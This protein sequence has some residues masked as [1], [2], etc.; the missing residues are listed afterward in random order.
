MDNDVVLPTNGV[1]KKWTNYVGGWQDRYFEIREGNLMYYKSKSEAPVGCRGSIYLKNAIITAHEFDECEFSISMGENVTWYL[2]AENAASKLLW[3]R[4]IVRETVQNDSDYSSTSTKS[5]SRNPSESSVNIAKNEDDTKLFASKLSELEAYRTMCKDQ[6]TSVERLLEQ[7]GASCIVPQPTILSVKA[8][9]LALI[10][11]INHI[12]DMVKSAKVVIPETS[13]SS[14]PPR[15][16]LH[17]TKSVSQ[18]ENRRESISRGGYSSDGNSSIMTTTSTVIASRPDVDVTSD[19]DE[20]F[21]ADEYDE[22]GRSNSVVENEK[23]KE[24]KAVQELPKRNMFRKSETLHTGHYDDLVVS[25]DHHLFDTIDKLAMEQLRYALAGVED[26]VWSLFAEDGP[27]RMYTRQIEDEGGVP[28]DPLKA[29]HCVKGVTALEFMHYFFDARYKLQWDHTLESM[30]VVEQISPDAV[31]LHQKHKT[32]WPAAPRESLF[33][34][35]I[36]RVDEH[37]RDGAHDLYIVCNR[38]VKRPDVPLASSSSVRVG[39]TVSMICETIVKDPHVDRP[40]SRDDVTC[41]VIYVSQVHPGGWVPTSALRHVYKKEYPKFLRTFTE[42]VQKNYRNEVFIPITVKRENQIDIGIYII[43]ETRED[44]EK[45]RMALDSVKCYA[46]Y[47]DYDLMIAHVKNTKELAEKCTQKDFMFRR[48]CAL[49]KLMESSKNSWI[50]FLDADMGVINPNNLIEKYIPKDNYVHFVFYNRIMNQE[51][52]A[53][54]YLAR[55]NVNSRNFLNFWANY[56]SKLPN[57]FHGSDNGAIH[58]VIVEYFI[59]ERKSQREFCEEKYWKTSIDYKSLTIYTVCIQKILKS[60]RL[61]K[62]LILEKGRFSWARDGWLSNSIWSQEDFILHGWQEKRLD[63]RIFAAWHSPIVYESPFNMGKCTTAEAHLNWRYKDSFISTVID[64]MTAIVVVS[65][66]KRSRRCLLRSLCRVRLEDK[67]LDLMACL[68]KLKEDLVVLESIF[69]KQHQRFQVINASVDEVTMKFIDSNGRSIII[70]ANIQENY[71]RQPPIWFSESDDVPAVGAALQRLTET[72]E[73]TNILHQVHRLIS[74]LCAYYNVST[75]AEL[76]HIAPPPREDVDEGQGS[77]VGDETEDDEQMLDDFNNGDSE[78]EDD[79]MGVGDENEEDELVQMAEE[80]PRSSQ[81]EGVPKEGLDMLDK[82]SRVNRQQHLDGKVKGSVTATDRLMKEIR[83]I[84]RSEHFKSGIYSF[85]LGEMDNL[86]EWWIKLNKVDED[87][88]L[89]ADMQVL[90]SEHKQ[91]HLLFH[92]MFNDQ[93]PFDPPFVRLV[94]PIITNGFVLSGGAICMELL[95]KNGW[96]SAYSVESIILQ[97]AATLVKGKARITFDHKTAP[98]YSLLRA[99][100]SFKS[101]VQI[102]NKSGW[103]TPPKG[104]G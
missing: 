90:K 76:P 55:N 75:P 34:S 57:S 33:V 20:F 72:T 61:K 28:V 3:M 78:M 8:T 83:D 21:D 87:S 56:E 16:P 77:D 88:L 73:S 5:H 46:K 59:P 41:N 50:L 31:V 49:A 1:L 42:F 100:Q 25:R 101:L 29:V 80:E 17:L 30:S 99:Q 43:L 64:I 36:R 94:A 13:R 18:C 9:H 11:N 38:D 62:I 2:K 93:F 74:E 54:S 84:Y 27:M 92:F 70:N 14:P 51:V 26:N 96:S 95:T 89:Y 15:E 23:R 19:C 37:K 32:V 71:P 7:G 39:L 86:Y 102:H 45:Y 104:D 67:F 53:G 85:E 69:P 44:E 63:K 79:E 81:D 82:V 97:I 12:I 48:H 6:M 60:A 91:D 47:F 68:R 24:E 103:Y 58:S 22:A 10:V 98:P 40:L 52:M 35:H 65:D 66:D 4:S